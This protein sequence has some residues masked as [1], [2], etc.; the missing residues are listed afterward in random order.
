MLLAPGIGLFSLQVE[1]IF[2]AIFFAMIAL[3]VASAFLVL[4][5]QLSWLTSG[6]DGRSFRLT[7]DC[8][9]FRDCCIRIAGCCGSA[10]CLSPASIS[11]PPVW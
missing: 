6:E 7:P 10:C 4:A 9:C 1:A 3:A 11:F 2:F 5:S 8:H